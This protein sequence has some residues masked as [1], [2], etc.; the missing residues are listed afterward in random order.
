VLNYRN[1]SYGEDWQDVEERV[2][3]ERTPCNYG[4]ERL[5]QSQFAADYQHLFGELPS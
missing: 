3:F 5:H 1:R 4:G 2:W